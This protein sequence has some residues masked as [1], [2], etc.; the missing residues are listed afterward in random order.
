MLSLQ[1]EKKEK[2][3]LINI[4]KGRMLIDVKMKYFD[5]K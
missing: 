3:R 2:N 1:I 4:I 5:K